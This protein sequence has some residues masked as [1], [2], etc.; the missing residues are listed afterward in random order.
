MANWA[1]GL[2]RT[3]TPGRP[4][5]KTRTGT[6][7]E[8]PSPSAKEDVTGGKDSNL[9]KK[10][11]GKLGMPKTSG[12]FTDSGSA[13]GIPLGRSRE[14]STLFTNDDQM[15]V[16]KQW[17]AE[18]PS[19]DQG[20]NANDKIQDPKDDAAAHGSHEPSQK[21]PKSDDL[22]SKLIVDL[23]GGDANAV[24]DPPR[25]IERRIEQPSNTL[26]GPEVD[27]EMVERLETQLKNGFENARN[28]YEEKTKKRNKS[29][30]RTGKDCDE[31]K[32]AEE[33]ENDNDLAET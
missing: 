14:S 3:A 15:Q 18:S 1:I 17:Q 30:K 16:D 25:N 13:R 26:I 23:T 6:N 4:L 10:N 11:N 32:T 7:T 20:S 33:D 29:L 24:D 19:K 22:A 9:V 31:D 5:K 8:R 27:R 21:T 2:P 28:E 12:G